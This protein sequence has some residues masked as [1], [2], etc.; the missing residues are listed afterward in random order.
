MA[1]AAFV[2]KHTVMKELDRELLRQ[3]KQ[4]EDSAFGM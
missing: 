3:Q 1:H 2:E 4:H